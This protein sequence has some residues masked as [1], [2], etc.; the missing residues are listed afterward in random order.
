M[1][2]AELEGH[3]GLWVEDKGRTV[4]VHWRRARDPAA[5]ALLADVA[6]TGIAESTGLHVEPG[7]MVAELCPPTDWDKGTA[8]AAVATEADL[9]TVVY[10]GDDRGDM[11]AFDAVK[12]RDGVAIG[13]DQGDET[14]APVRDG[15]DLLL[16]GASGVRRWLEDLAAAL[17]NEPA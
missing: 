2:A 1:L 6:V 12:A 9:R 10:V 15:T 7:K 17:G 11:P 14:P 3:D 16:P 13:V 5:A 8:V 4:A